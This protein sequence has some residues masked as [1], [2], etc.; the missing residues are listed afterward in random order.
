MTYGLGLVP[1]GVRSLRHYGIRVTWQRTK[2]KLRPLSARLMRRA[3]FTRR[4]LAAQRVTRFERDILFSVVVPLYNTPERLL[5][6]MIR[7]VTDQTYAN[8]EL[9]L[10]DGS[11][12]SHPEVER[13]CLELAG[14]DSRIKYRRLERNLG[15][16]GNTNACLEMATGDYVA[17]LDHDDLL[18]PA[19]LFEVMRAICGTDADFVYTD[20]AK[21]RQSPKDAFDPHFKPA[22]AP[23]TLRGNN[24]ICH[25][26]VFAKGLLDEVGGFDPN[27]DGAQDF[28]LVLRLTERARLVVHVPEVLYYWR[29]SGGSSAKDSGAKPY[30]I[31]AGVRS[32]DK[33]LRRLGLEG[34]VEP[35]RDGLTIYRVRYALQGT[36]KVSI[37]IPSHE[38]VDDLE[39]CIGSILERTTYPEYGIVVVEN[40]STSP[41]VFEYYDRIQREDSRVR[42]VTWEG[43]GFDFP[44]L[45]DLGARCSDGEY[46]LLLNNDI[47][48]ITPDWIQEMLMFA[49]RPDVGVVGAKLLYPDGTIQHAGVGIGL[50]N[51]AGHFF[52]GVEERHPG[53][54]GRL[55]YAQD[56]SAVTGA[57][58]LMRRDIWD[59]LDGFDELFS[60]DFNDI[61]LCM[62]ARKAGY[63]VVW[64]PF[65][66]LV[67]YESAT[68]ES[69]RTH[70][71][72]EEFV[73]SVARFRRRWA[74]E[75]EAG[76]PYYNP[77]F[78]LAR[79][80]FAV[81]V[82]LHRPNARR[83]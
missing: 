79:T 28:D 6:A 75:L 31:D 37:V 42:V 78:S 1:K 71:H 72:S 33:Q 41:E 18:H 57:C 80:D 82:P 77:N 5:R 39:R 27:C 63:L 29:A 8:W 3:D 50:L 62:R 7:S 56:L 2:A 58:M 9:C 59:E 24:Y 55:M 15:I 14:Q 76:D 38:H 36:P 67:H 10:A 70:V 25:L 32:V 21:C 34:K 47:Q 48:V 61:D 49:Q 68:R 23:D 26:S 40:N 13:I 51:L 45:N 43:E 52:R 53:Y 83:A 65:A 30:A 74:S 73:A 81:E 44:A 17:L 12:A 66:E 16:S 4:E 46:L 64:T 22:F 60:V 20:E 54:M 19:A 69:G 11:D 35:V